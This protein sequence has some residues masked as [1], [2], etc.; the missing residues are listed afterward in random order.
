MINLREAGITP[1]IQLHD[2]LN[3]SYENE[4]GADKIKEIM[5]Q[6]V[7]TKST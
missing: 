2:E 3:V 4:Q 6:A 1:M 5:E 7:P